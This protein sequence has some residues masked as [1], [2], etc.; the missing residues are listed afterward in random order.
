M[1]IQELIKNKIYP[2]ILDFTD[3]YGTTCWW[4]EIRG[5]K[6]YEQTLAISEV[7]GY[8]INFETYDECLEAAIKECLTILKDEKN[9]R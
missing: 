4:F 8:D 3:V 2:R 1:T 5:L 7:L 9:T 6:D